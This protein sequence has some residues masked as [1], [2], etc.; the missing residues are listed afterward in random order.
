M[1]IYRC[2]EDVRMAHDD[3]EARAFPL[4]SLQSGKS[5]LREINNMLLEVWDDDFPAIMWGEHAQ[6]E[7]IIVNFE[8]LFLVCRSSRQL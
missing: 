8:L 5:T 3:P 7:T 4:L 1:V 6:G 2:I